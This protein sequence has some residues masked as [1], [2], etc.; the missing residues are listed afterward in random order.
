VLEDEEF[1]EAALEV[2]RIYAVR[3]TPLQPVEGVVPELPQ[4]YAEFADVFSEAKAVTL[5]PLGGPEHAIEL[6]GGEPPY[7][8]IYS[9]LEQELKVLHEYLRDAMERGWIRESNSPAG[10]PILFTPKK[11]S[12]LCLCVN[13]RGLNRITRKNWY[14]L[15][16][17]SKILNRVVGAKHYTKIDLCNAYH[18][19]CIRSSNE[20]KTVFRTWY[21][22]FEYQVL[23]F[24]LANAPATFQIYINQA[25][26]GLVNIT[27][28]VYLD[29]IL[30]F[31]V[32]P[33]DHHRHITEVLRRLH[34]YGLYTKLSKCQFGVDTV[35]FLGYVLSPG[36]ITMECSWVNMIAE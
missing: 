29:D 9:L 22:Q 33:K 24:G 7:G 35:D 5:P 26:Q 3:Y 8:P 4:E 18:R 32:N 17:I 36:G 28:V 31:S 11:G 20:W 15:P 27:C 10:A 34:K 21:S 2:G 13:Y 14:P 19:I 12:E 6:E 25:L 30:I 16:L 23:P 1:A